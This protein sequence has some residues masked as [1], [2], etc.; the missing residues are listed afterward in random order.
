[1]GLPGPEIE[2]LVQNRG[3]ETGSLRPDTHPRVPGLVR[4]T[5]RGGR[6]WLTRPA[7]RCAPSFTLCELSATAAGSGDGEQDDHEER[8]RPR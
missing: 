8:R 3:E 6:A 5:G 4:T 7:P 1:M 2:L